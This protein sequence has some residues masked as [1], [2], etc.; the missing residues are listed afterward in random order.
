MWSL[1]TQRLLE[2]LAR[3]L[4]ELGELLQ[5]RKFGERSQTKKFE[6]RLGRAV[7]HGSTGLVL[8]TEDP[9]QVPIQQPLEHRS[10]VNPS[11]VVDFRSRN[12]LSV[13]HD[14]ERLELSA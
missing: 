13:C 1:F 5:R 4:A 10:A 6:K 14:S 11:H 12:R 9:D 8:L 2:V 7:E 3:I